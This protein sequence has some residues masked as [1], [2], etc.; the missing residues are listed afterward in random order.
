[1]IW[2][3][4][5]C[6]PPL[7]DTAAPPADCD[8]ET[9]APDRDGDGYGAAAGLFTACE[10]PSGF[11]ADATDC[12]DTDAAAHPG[13]AEACNSRDD[14]CDGAA[15]PGVTTWADTDGDGYGDPATAACVGGAGRVADATDCDDT[16]ATTHP[17]ADEGCDGADANCDGDPDDAPTTTWYTDT[18][19]DGYGADAFEACTPPAGAA[20]VGGDCA[21]D[22]PDA[23]PDADE[24]CNEGDDDCDGDIDEGCLI[25]GDVYLADADARVV[26]D[27]G[28]ELGRQLKVGDVT[29]DGVDDVVTGTLARGSIGGAAVLPGGTLASGDIDALGFRIEAGAA[30][31]GASRSVGVGDID[32]DGVD[33]IGI[34]VPYATA[35]GVRILL[36]PVTADVTLESG[37]WLSAP[38]GVFAGHG[39]DVGDVDGD[40]LADA[41]IGAHADSTGGSWA[42]AVYVV[43]GPI[44]TDVDLVG[45]GATR[46][47]STE[48]NSGTGR[49]I[50]ADGDYNGDGVS[51]LLVASPLSSYAGTQAG[52]A[53]VVYGP[54]TD[55]L[56]FAEADGRFYST[57]PGDYFGTGI[58]HGDV[59]GDGTDDVLVGGSGASTE[60][61]AYVFL[62]SDGEY[63]IDDAALRFAGVSVAESL[64]TDL[65]AGDLDGDGAGDL[66]LGAY[67]ASAYDGAVY[68]FRGPAPG[69]YGPGDADVALLGSG[70]ETA[71]N[72]VQLGDL[73]AD[74]RLELLVG[75][76]AASGAG[77]LYVF[78]GL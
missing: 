23:H 73:D 25:V 20:P 26:G 42:G 64:G 50:R 9:W 22:D 49:W 43:Y 14:D 31:S 56:D 1:M 72:S 40:G 55:G 27:R 76:P 59:D 77:A 10:A 53:Y 67:G 68:L 2:A 37:H 69:V 19:G 46:L 13:A 41:V 54:P 70:R 33:D 39:G 35:D 44:T 5:A 51:D 47:E 7:A 71:G 60:G 61:S 48:A 28:D 4:L 12:D 18:D 62:A 16:N 6:T 29:G 32:G 30:S 65:R 36:G 34:G 21:P 38:T 78:G 15:D 17:G 57:R 63:T 74:G 24:S 66:V 45:D 3:L 11:V 75:A 52:A 8:T 58:G